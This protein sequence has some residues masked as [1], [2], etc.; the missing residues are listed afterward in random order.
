M[1]LLQLPP[2]GLYVHLPWCERKCPYCDFNSHEFTELPEQAYVDCLLADLEREIAFAQGRSIS[3]LFIGGGT[4]SL[5]SAGAITRLLQGIAARLPLA[6][7]MEATMEA[8][9]GSAEAGKFAAFRA[10]GINRLSLGIQSF[11]ATQLRILG[12]VH[13]SD[14]AHSAV[15]AAR[16]AGFQR[17]NLD[18]MHGLPQQD[19]ALALADLATAM[20]YDTGHLSWYQL[21][22]EPNTV[23]HKRPP[24]LP[25][26][27]ELAD[28]QDAGEAQLLAGGL[29]QYEVSAWA[30]PGQECRHNLNYWSFGD[31][32]GIGA[33]A[34]GKV[35]FTD[36]R[37][38]RYAKR[39]QP[40]AYMQAGADDYRAQQRW[41]QA[42]ELPGEFAMNAL[43]LN[44]G[45][46]LEQFSACTGLA[47]GALQPALDSLVERQLLVVSG[48]R[49]TA[50]PLGRR[51]LDSVVAEFLPD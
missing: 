49:L 9:P 10:A 22:I 3:T 17:I 19:A 43:R 16:N 8:N 37:I 44:A 28:I 2:L 25:V 35:S 48:N 12:R 13:D 31:Y 5:F 18:L 30:I 20:E 45:F 32:L 4:P 23:F 40:E 6:A 41:L 47:A 21:T 14:Q 42:E 24:L 26:E 39:R 33:G 50:S 51:F 34:H 7:H 46:T 27:D 15:T 38:M 36:G 1:S 29:R 11:Q